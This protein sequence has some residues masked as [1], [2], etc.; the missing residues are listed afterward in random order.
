MAGKTIGEPL[1][2][3][4]FFCSRVGISRTAANMQYFELTQGRQRSLRDDDQNKT[5]LMLEDLRREW[6]YRKSLEAQG[7][8][9]Q[10][11]YPLNFFRVP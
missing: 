2:T 7:R 1:S 6:G 3:E 4:S 8:T 11:C 5:K 10:N 9:Y